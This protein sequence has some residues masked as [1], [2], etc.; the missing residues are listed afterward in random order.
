LVAAAWP[1]WD[2]SFVAW[3]ALLPWFSAL[4]R[5]RRVWPA[6]ALGWWLSFLIGL[7]A[8]YWVATAAHEF[9]EL[10]WTA[11]V[12]VLVIFAATCAHPH[13][14]I[15]GALVSWAGRR[16]RGSLGSSL[17]ACLCLALLYAGLDWVV[18][19][20]FDAGLGYALHDQ[21]RLRQ[22]ADLG[23]VP[24]LTFLVVLVNLLAWRAWLAFRSEPRSSALAAG[25]LVLIGVAWAAGAGYGEARI[26]AAA[27]EDSHAESSLRVG[28][29]QGN[30]S[31][32]T[33]LA[34]ARGDDRAAEKQ[35]S[36]YMLPTEELA[37]EDPPPDLIVWPEATFPGIFQQ[38]LSTFQR[39]RANKLDRQLLRLQTP[40][41]FGAYD[42]QPKEGKALLYNSLFAITPRYDSPGA[43]GFVQRY[44]KHRL[45]PFAET[46]PGLSRTPWVREHLPS[47]G[48][49]G[50]GPGPGRF[51][52]TTPDGLEVV[53]GPFI[54]S[55]S[56]S[57]KHVIETARLGVDVLLNVGSDGWFG[58]FGEPQFHL[59][60]AR[61]RSVETRR[62]QIRAANTGISAFILATGEIAARSLVA[63]ETTLSGS[64]ALANHPESLMMR[65]GDWFGGAALALGLLLLL[66]LL[67]VSKQ[68]DA[69][70]AR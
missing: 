8:G 10:S 53:L 31:N 68:N 47:L 28:I 19:R 60:V 58:R 62:P 65:W 9:L 23:G 18:P 37:R 49:F 70:V 67:V 15:L 39:G 11:S 64:M 12:A 25:H 51:V 69:S 22:L 41:V 30:V 35:L 29:V 6:L 38:P 43:L 16:T 40:V 13:L 52:I 24:L 54:C 2:L 50:M 26:R 34:W 55:E 56:L 5:Q 17:L 32:E 27:L 21:P 36:S 48:F 1:P 20:L 46:I 57:S 42:R 61:L 66:L 14:V 63:E 33:R 3:F 45:L 44:H 59:A 7:L 4:E